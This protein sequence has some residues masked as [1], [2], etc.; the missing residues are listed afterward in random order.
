MGREL[1]IAT[2]NR[3]K[4]IKMVATWYVEAGKYNVYLSIVEEFY[5]L[6]TDDQ[7]LQSKEHATHIILELR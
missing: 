2:D 1:N 5:V 7:R 4:L 3:P 6:A